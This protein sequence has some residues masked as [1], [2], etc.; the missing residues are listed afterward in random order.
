[1]IVLTS[2]C[3]TYKRSAVIH[4]FLCVFLPLS[5]IVFHTLDHCLARNC[6]SLVLS[7]FFDSSDNG[8]DNGSCVS[9]VRSS[10]EHKNDNSECFLRS[11]MD[12]WSVHNDRS[13]L[14]WLGEVAVAYWIRVGGGEFCII[15][16]LEIYCFRSTTRTSAT[17]CPNC[18]N[19]VMNKRLVGVVHCVCWKCNEITRPLSGSLD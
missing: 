14:W 12:W 8:S 1:M 18:A 19:R 3:A 10:I 17:I 9:F 11:I 7:Q 2:N 13:M 4:T 15:Q 6:W 5:I 16:V